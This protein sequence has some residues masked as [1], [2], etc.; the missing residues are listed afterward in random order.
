MVQKRVKRQEKSLFCQSVSYTHT[1]T[2]VLTH[3]NPQRETLSWG[4]GS[5]KWHFVYI[6]RM[7]KMFFCMTGALI[8]WD[9][10][11]HQLNIFYLEDEGGRLQRV[12]ISV[13]LSAWSCTR[14][15]G[16][17][18]CGKYSLKTWK[19][20]EISS[21]HL[22]LNSKPVWAPTTTLTYKEVKRLKNIIFKFGKSGCHGRPPKQ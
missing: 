20:K 3:T 1:H 5:C 16:C 18:Q 4:D 11:Y 12:N 22:P 2:I 8:K 10:L 15:R 7:R 9:C 14:C 19:I 17:F 13:C 21:H 6:M